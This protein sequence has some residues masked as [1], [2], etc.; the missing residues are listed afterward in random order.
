MPII[1]LSFS[2]IVILHLLF[3]CGLEL[4][5]CFSQ[6][7]LQTLALLG[8]PLQLLLQLLQTC[9]C[10]L[11]RVVLLMVKHTILLLEFQCKYTH[12]GFYN[13]CTM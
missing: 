1:D 6:F 13:S 10:L 9:D 11:V 2:S 7:F 12:H 5:L 3:N 8:T 4:G